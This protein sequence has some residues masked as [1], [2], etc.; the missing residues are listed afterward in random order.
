MCPRTKKRPWSQR[1]W[2][3]RPFMGKSGGPAVT[4]RAKGSKEEEPEG[5]RMGGRV[6]P[7]GL[8]I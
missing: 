3:N 2:G 6:P 7:E 8:Q 4:S 5:E 1:G